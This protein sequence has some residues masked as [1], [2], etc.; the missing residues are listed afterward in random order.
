[1]KAGVIE[2]Q[3]GQPQRGRDE[4]DAAIHC[5]RLIHRWH[6]ECSVC[7]PDIGGLDIV[8]GVV[9]LSHTLLHLARKVTNLELSRLTDQVLDIHARGVF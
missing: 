5:L 7:R 9:K 6:R 8:R 2:R 1:M 4:Q 3:H